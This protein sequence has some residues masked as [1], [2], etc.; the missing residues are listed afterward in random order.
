ML[1]MEILAR[2]G[3]M[4]ENE[5]ALIER[6]PARGKRAAL[7]WKQFDD[8]ANAVANSLVVRGVKKG[9]RVIQLMTN[10]LEW[11]PTYFGILRTGAWVVPL[12]YRFTA[13]D[14]KSCAEIAEAKALVF[15][16]K[17]VERINRIKD[18][19]DRSIA[20]YVYVGPEET[21]P[22]YAESY[23]D[24][25][26]EGSQA[27]PAIAISLYDPAGLY[28]TSGTTG[29]PKATLLT[30]RNLEFACFLENRHHNQTHTDNFLCIPPL[31]HT[32]AK[33]HWFGNFVVG[34]KAV[35]LKGVSPQWILE[36]ISE[37]NVTIVWLLVPWAL[38][39]LFA[40][41]SREVNLNDYHLA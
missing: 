8:Q 27:D 37:E 11:L 34:A 32:G 5:I 3:R 10:C 26:A 15:G 39:I 13:D 36:A 2:N 22:D 12:N 1:I 19:L 17:F 24:I 30:H 33:M 23:G 25:V 38:D 14:I 20:H 40:I 18:P 6:E 16:E 31:Y 21:R 29:T 28:F 4:Y 9:D 7:T 41:E 35:I